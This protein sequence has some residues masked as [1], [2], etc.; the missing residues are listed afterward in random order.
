MNRY[1]LLVALLITPPLAVS[2]LNASDGTLDLSFGGS[3]TGYVTVQ[4][5]TSTF[6]C[7]AMAIQTDG[8]ILIAGVSN[9]IVRLNP[10]G[11]PDT[12]F[13]T[14]GTG[15]VTTTLAGIFALL[16]QPDG[17]IVACGFDS[18]NNG[19]LTRY[20]SAGII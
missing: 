3:G 2:S 11:S 7:Y 9:Q 10:N 16:I 14:A 20:T 6:V 15:V 19:S 13:G 8:K 1:M 5:V 17:S 18:S 4:N 12:T